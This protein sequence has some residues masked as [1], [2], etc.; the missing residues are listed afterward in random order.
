M[1]KGETKPQTTPSTVEEVNFNKKQCV[2]LLH[3]H[4]MVNP[5]FFVDQLPVFRG[6]AFRP[7]PGHQQRQVV[8]L[9]VG[10]PRARERPWAAGT[11]RAERG[12]NVLAGRQGS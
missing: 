2:C 9:R 8:V 1:R 4:L 6:K 12:G 3:P 11:L 7:P 5:I 10:A